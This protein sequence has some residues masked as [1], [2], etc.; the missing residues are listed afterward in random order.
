MKVITVRWL[1]APRSA[2][3]TRRLMRNSGGRMPYETAWRL[4]RLRRH[5]DE[6]PYAKASQRRR[7]GGTGEE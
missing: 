2:L 7:R 4:A 6:L 5:P 3:R 1:L